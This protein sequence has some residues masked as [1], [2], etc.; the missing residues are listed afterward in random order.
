MRSCPAYVVHSHHTDVSIVYTDCG[1]GRHTYRV[2]TLQRCMGGL[3]RKARE[4]GIENFAFMCE[5]ILRIR[6]L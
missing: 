4:S 6:K 3:G 5:C 2:W 1:P